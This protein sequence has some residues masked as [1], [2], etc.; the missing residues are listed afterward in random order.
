MKNKLTIETKMDEETLRKLLYIANAEGRTPNNHML[1]LI[2]TN[3]AYFERIHGKI[4][5]KDLAA[6]ALPESDGE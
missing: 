4:T 6:V 5:P 2:R 1:S 3:I